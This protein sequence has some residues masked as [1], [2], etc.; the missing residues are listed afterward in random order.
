MRVFAALL[1]LPALTGIPCSAQSDNELLQAILCEIRELRSAFL[2]GQMAT[3]MLDANRREREFAVRRLDEVVE[4]QREAQ[5]RLQAMNTRMNEV[6]QLLRDLRR[7]DRPD[8][9]AGEREQQVTQLEYERRELGQAIP[10]VQE[11]VGR[12][13][14]EASALRARISGFETEYERLQAQMRSW[15]PTA[16]RSARALEIDVKVALWELGEPGTS[17]TTMRSISSAG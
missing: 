7:N 11:D 4:R 8:A 2:Q 1:L 15:P 12:T 13:S 16:A 17:R 6:L 3:P 14:D 10:Q 5:E 9:T